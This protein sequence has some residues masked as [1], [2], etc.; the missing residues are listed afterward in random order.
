MVLGDQSQQPDEARK[1]RVGV[2]THTSAKK[3]TH[4]TAKEN[5]TIQSAHLNRSI[6]FHANGTDGV[7][8]AKST[9]LVGTSKNDR[10]LVSNAHACCVT[11]RHR[12]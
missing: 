4:Y 5:D 6:G 7:Q 1:R 3:E 11:T 9:R 8:V 12:Q 2:R 10:S